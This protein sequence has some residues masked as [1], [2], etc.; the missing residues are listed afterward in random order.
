[1]NLPTG[2]AFHPGRHRHRAGE[3]KRPRARGGGGRQ[4]RDSARGVRFR[5]RRWCRTNRNETG[6]APWFP[7]LQP[8]TRGGGRTVR[9]DVRAPLHQRPR[10]RRLLRQRPLHQPSQLSRHAS[11]PRKSPPAHRRRR[12]RLKRHRQPHR[13]LVSHRASLCITLLHRASPRISLHQSASPV[14]HKKSR[15]GSRTPSAFPSDR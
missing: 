14:N 11:T 12:N 1:M 4:L 9:Q 15:G 8:G 6:C 2:L 7:L 3:I 13:A 5:L 10:H